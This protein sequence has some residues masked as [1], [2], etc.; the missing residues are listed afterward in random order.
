MK[1]TNAKALVTAAMLAACYTALTVALAPISY[2]MV[3]VRISEAFT[4]LP[5]YSPVAIWGV[6]VGC[7]L[8]NLIGLLMGAN[9]LGA[10]DILFG[11]LATVIAAVFSYWLRRFRIRGLPVLSALP[12]VLVN[13]IIIGAELCYVTVGSFQPSVF[14][15]QALWVGLGEAIS[16]FCLGLPLCWLLERKGLHHKLFG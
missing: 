8:S 16:C 9:I 15:I 4:L 10:L 2:G 11:T 13:A 6:S 3:Q 1:R 14:L 5:I 12:P 7:L